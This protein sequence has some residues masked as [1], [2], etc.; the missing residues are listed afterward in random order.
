MRFPLLHLNIRPMQ[1]AL[2][3]EMTQICQICNLQVVVVDKNMNSI[4]SYIVRIYD[5][6]LGWLDGR[7]V[8]NK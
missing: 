7:K 6:G 3:D 5:Y 2:K 8:E 4:F 1:T